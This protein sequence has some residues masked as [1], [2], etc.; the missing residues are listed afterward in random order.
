MIVVFFRGNWCPYCNLELKA[1]QE[2]LNS[3]KTKDVTLV[4]ISPQSIHYNDELKRNLQLDF[5]LLRDK[6]NTLARQL[7]L[8]FTLQ[9]D[10][11]SV[12]HNLG[13]DLS[14]YND[15]NDNE[16]PI[17]AVFVLDTSGNITYK[18]IDSN[19]MNR[20]DIQELIKQL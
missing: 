9:E 8:S 13:I 4:A 1:L 16:L 14:H 12:Y 2:H 6:D 17:S 5:Q 11:V 19:Y 20:I 3:I 15:N 7:G 10:V 18:F